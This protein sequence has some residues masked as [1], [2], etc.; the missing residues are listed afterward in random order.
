M[1][2]CRAWL[3]K[4]PCAKDPRGG[5]RLMVAAK[6]SETT[7]ARVECVA[8]PSKTL[9]MGRKMEQV[10]AH[11]FNLGKGKPYEEEVPRAL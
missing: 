1:N 3:T 2:E 11:L 5:A 4:A 8:G 9:D 6:T 10:N 7:H